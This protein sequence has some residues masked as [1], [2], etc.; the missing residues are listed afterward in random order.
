MEKVAMIW[1]EYARGMGTTSIGL[2]AESELIKLGLG[3][4]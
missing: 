3:S 4:R 2:M 1:K